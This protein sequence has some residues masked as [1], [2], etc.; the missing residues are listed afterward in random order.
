VVWGWLVE[1]ARTQALDGWVRN[2]TDGSVEAVLA[3][4]P[5]TVR[6]LIERCRIGPTLARVERIDATE[7]AEA[8]PPGFVERPR[9]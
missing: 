6:A 9:L 5:A 7:T 1:Q 8:P 3:C 4:D 2:W